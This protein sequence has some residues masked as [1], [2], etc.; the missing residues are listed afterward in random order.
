M[1]RISAAL[2]QRCPPV[3]RPPAMLSDT[4]LSG[5]D[6]RVPDPLPTFPGLAA[7]ADRYDLLF[8]DVWGVLHNGAT[9]HAGA[10]QAIR[11]F[12]DAGGT[13]AL[14]S[15]SPQRSATVERHLT[16][17]GFAHDDWDFIVTAGDVAHEQFGTPPWTDVF[18]IGPPRDD[19]LFAGADVSRVPLEDAQSVV[20]TGLVDDRTETPDSYR[21]LLADCL[22]RDLPLLCANPDRIVEVGEAMLPCAG[23]LAEIYED[24]G[25][26]VLWA[27]KPHAAIYDQAR[28]IAAKRRGQPVGQSRILAIGD[29][30]LTDVPGAHGFGVDVVFVPDGIHRADLMSGGKAN[31]ERIAAALAPYADAVV[32]ITPRLYWSVAPAIA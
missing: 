16:G 3:A 5:M 28:A 27:G 32:G 30:L 25:G 17:M 8:C 19:G 13:V 2:P 26:T 15:N 11:A 1:F 21:P 24:M 23:A 29:G 31:D 6:A 7:W 12:R 14:V 9:P 18:H 10:R 4:D 22:E 20:C